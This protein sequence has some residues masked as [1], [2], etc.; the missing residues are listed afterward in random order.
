MTIFTPEQAIERLGLS[1]RRALPLGLFPREL[2]EPARPR[3]L[4]SSFADAFRLTWVGG[5]L[6]WGQESVADAF[7]VGREHVQPP[8]LVGFKNAA[9]RRSQLRGNVSPTKADYNVFRDED[10]R[11]IPYDDWDI[12]DDTATPQEFAEAFA[13]YKY[14]R[15]LEDRLAGDGALGTLAHVTWGLVDPINLVPLGWLSRGGRGVGAFVSARRIA[16]ATV[17]GAAAAATVE[18]LLQLRD[19]ARKAEDAVDFVLGSAALGAF[20]GV[21]SEAFRG[22]TALRRHQRELGRIARLE[23]SPTGVVT[24]DDLNSVADDAARAALI[25]ERIRQHDQNLGAIYHRKRS[26]GFRVLKNT[27]RFTPLWRALTAETPTPKTLAALLQDD[28]LLRADETLGSPVSVRAAGWKERMSRAT[29]EVGKQWREYKRARGNEIRTRQEFVEHV[30][31][32]LRRGGEAPSLQTEEARTAVRRAAQIYRVEDDALLA[33]SIEQGFITQEESKLLKGTALTHFHR[34]WDQNRVELDGEELRQ[35]FRQWATEQAVKDPEKWAEDAYNSVR[36]SPTGVTDLQRVDLADALQDRMI[37]VP[38]ERIEKYLISDADEIMHRVVDQLGPQIEMARTFRAA[39]RE[40][41]GLRDRLQGAIRELEGGNPFPLQDLADDLGTID[42]VQ[43]L[44]GTL[45]PDD[46]VAGRR[47]KALLDLTRPMRQEL[48]AL[49]GRAQADKQLVDAFETL[50]AREGQ[51][52]L[53]VTRSFLER[54]P[55]TVKKPLLDD[56]ERELL[57]PEV[58]AAEQAIAAREAAERT[59][60]R[61]VTGLQEVEVAT[62]RAELKTARDL[63]RADREAAAPL[64]AEAQAR[65]VTAKAALAEARRR[66]RRTHAQGLRAARVAERRA[67]GKLEVAR[68]RILR[69]PE[70]IARVRAVFEAIDRGAELK[71]FEATQK[72]LA[73]T[74]LARRPIR[75]RAEL[76]QALAAMDQIQIAGARDRLTRANEEIQA[77]REALAPLDE[78]MAGLRARAGVPQQPAAPLV[79]LTTGAERDATAAR[80]TT[81]LGNILRR[82]ATQAMELT[83]YLQKGGIVWQEY[84][85]LIDAAP[86][87]S[88]ERLRIAHR[89]DRRLKDLERIRDRILHRDLIWTDPSSVAART[90]GIVQNIAY[91]VSL[92]GVVLSSVPD[93][94]ML[95]FVNGMRPLIPAIQAAFG[96]SRAAFRARVF[97]SGE[98][99]KE[100]VVSLI[101]AV[102]L[103]RAHMGSRLANLYDLREPDIRLSRLERFTRS[104]TGV[105]TRLTGL[106]Y[107]NA[108]LNTV[109]SYASMNRLLKSSVKLLRGEK[110]SRF[111][112]QNLKLAGLR[113]ADAIEIGRAY[114]K[115]GRKSRGQRLAQSDRWTDSL[116]ETRARRHLL[117]AI[118]TDVRRTI[119]VAGAAD[120]PRLASQPIARLLFMFK[121]FALATTTRV[122]MSGL[123]RWDGAVLQGAVALVTMGMVSELLKGLTDT[124][125]KLSDDPRVWIR[126][127]IDRSGAFGIFADAVNHTESASGLLGFGPFFG[128]PERATRHSIQSAMGQLL[129]PA[130]GTI[131]D[132]V[133][134]G[135]GGRYLAGRVLGERDRASQADTHAVRRVVWGQNLFYL[136]WLFDSLEHNSNRFLGLPTRR[137]STRT[138]QVRTAQ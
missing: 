105:F 70:A 85:A 40:L 16:G 134:A 80:V 6:A 50:A 88:H 22:L 32:A 63:A 110:L 84:Q 29:L 48:R 4:V 87:G 3:P 5:L 133:R 103:T 113:G 108:T 76:G 36:K 45:R 56:L 135:V 116:E 132:L 41:A 7:G 109:A 106:P 46:A 72:A 86:A 33:D 130:Y 15:L 94:G 2:P 24:V 43:R 82:D 23:P 54:L 9:L 28:A 118:R 136:K 53:E 25:V 124:R 69:R 112:R 1:E 78:E 127:G 12:F 49:E 96:D 21:G 42:A 44:M 26:Y 64:V 93:V 62:A 101:T 138:G 75:A 11:S 47:L 125:R 126:N 100:E 74:T 120:A 35:V 71:G 39:T 30:G 129:G 52:E 27:L 111:E 73:S 121:R 107:W 18:P 97:G 55:A 122:L 91:M 119:I 10:L 81:L 20:L 17:T 14:D 67:M 65:L 13:R 37:L 66:D 60:L 8:E 83:T 98:M 59:P 92:G 102:E 51:G 61:E 137:P 117:D 95:V 58:E 38:D 34:V 89:R 131:E 114:L 77:R 90:E 115:H 68:T 99:A 128:L 31:R 79:G 123:Q 104:A 57:G 19:P